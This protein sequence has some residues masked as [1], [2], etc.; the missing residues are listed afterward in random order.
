[1]RL[2]VH[3]EFRAVAEIEAEPERRV[4]RDAAAV[5]DDLGDAV[6]RNAH[7]LGEPVLRQL[8]LGE[9]FLLQHFAGR[10]RRKFVGSH[11]ALP[12]VIVDDPDLVRLAF[13]PAQ[14]DAPL[15]VDPDRVKAAQIALQ[16]FEPVRRRHQQIF[17]PACRID[18]FQ[19]A[20]GRPR[21]ALKIPDEFVLEQRFGPLVAE[22]ADHPADCTESRYTVKYSPAQPAAK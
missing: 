21:E 7:G 11:R 6:R 8:I 17:E 3:P 20:L 22:G 13:D 15:I 18:R 14:D 16:F 5:V 19:L 10:D 1:M 12:S 2:Q 9:E 4:R